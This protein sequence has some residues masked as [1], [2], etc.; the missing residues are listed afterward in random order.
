MSLK[1]ATKEFTS[2]KEKEK[3]TTSD[4]KQR[5]SEEVMMATPDF[6]ITRKG[7]ELMNNIINEMPTKFGFQ[8]IKVIEQTI[9]PTNK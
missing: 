8:L 1:G 9:T 6:Y 5:M 3:E 7:L 4:I 2:N